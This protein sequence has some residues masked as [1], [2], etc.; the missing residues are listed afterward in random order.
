MSFYFSLTVIIL[1]LTIFANIVLAMLVI[2]QNKNNAT[3]DIFFFLSLQISMWLFVMYRAVNPELTLGWARLTIFFAAPM[4]F[5]FFL[6][7]HTLPSPRLLLPRRKLIAGCIAV[8]AIM[9]LAVSP[10]TFTGV[11][12]INGRPEVTPGIGMGFFAVFTLYFF[13]AALMSLYKKFRHEANIE[14]KQ[15][16]LMMYGILTMIGLLIFTVL[17]PALF[18]KRFFVDYAPLYTLIFL[19]TTAIAILKY[20]LFNVKIIAT[21]LLVVVLSFTLIVEAFLSNSIGSL[22]FRLLFAGLVIFLGVLLIRSVSKEIRQR[23][24]LEAANLRLQELDRQK[25]DFL[26]IAS[27]QL[28]TPLSILNG[29]LGLL[30]EGSYG[31]PSGEMKE[32]FKNMDESNSRLIKLVDE[33]LDITRFEQ[34]RTKF[35]FLPHKLSDIIDDVVKEL[36]PRA[37]QKGLR[38]VWDS[39]KDDQTVDVDDEKIR[40]A[41]FN[42]VD[43][44]IKYSESGDVVILLEEEDNGLTC[45]IMDKGIGFD[46][47]DRVNFFQK[48]YRG[49][50]VQGTNVTGTGLGLYVVSKFIEGHG[51]KV[52]ARSSGLGKGSEFGFWIPYG[53]NARKEGFNL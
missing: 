26:S 47:K 41:V 15:L 36:A 50:N 1:A 35:Y 53:K 28:R 5:L 32:V 49:E 31:K 12:I 20:R 4:N 24:E 40:H 3:N 18:K 11:E 51:G 7:A 30:E 2:K 6:L 17:I 52:W 16:Q 13:S 10:F 22:I 14:R 34:G 21:E 44:A 19:G 8:I 25:T 29:Y 9:A 23:E 48:F 46:E 38:L 39:K 37:E 42:F 45:K 27:H 33:F 43:N